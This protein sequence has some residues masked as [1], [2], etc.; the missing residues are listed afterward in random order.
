MDIKKS[1]WGAF[2]LCKNCGPISISKAAE[3]ESAA[4]GGCGYKLNKKY[5][6]MQEKAQ[7]RPKRVDYENRL[8]T[9]SELER[10]WD[11]PKE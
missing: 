4:S 9:L 7:D 6:E 5:R 11:K 10:M 3:M 1:K 8:Y 2:F